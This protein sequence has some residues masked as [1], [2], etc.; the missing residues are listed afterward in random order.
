MPGNLRSKIKILVEAR[1]QE[2]GAAEMQDVI[3][4]LIMGWNPGSVPR[5][6]V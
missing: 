2:I 3:T 1:N 5:K 6:L 4:V